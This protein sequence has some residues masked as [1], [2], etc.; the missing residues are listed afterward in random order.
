MLKGIIAALSLIA[1]AAPLS[2]I[3]ATRFIESRDTVTAGVLVKDIKSAGG[4]FGDKVAMAALRL[5]GIPAGEALDNDSIGAAVIGFSQLDDLGFVNSSLALAMASE[6]SLAAWRDYGDALVGVSRRKG[7]DN[8]FAGK[9]IYGSDWVGDNIYRGNLVELT[10]RYSG[11]NTFRTKSLDKVTFEK[12]KYPALSDSTCY[13][14]VRMIEMGFRTHKIP[15][16]K[17]ETI[18]KKEILGDM[19]DGDIVILLGNDPRFDYY[20]IGIVKMR[21]DGPHLVHVNETV[22]KVMEESEPLVRWMKRE[23]K[24]FYGY[25]WLRPVK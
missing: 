24:R 9:M 14:A 25:R 10:E 22:G 3:A 21:A 19:R 7:V 15:H 17:K 8:G 23:T 1:G 20:D 18:S 12:E 16:L 5:E 2:C 11:G 13:D 6:T 4:S